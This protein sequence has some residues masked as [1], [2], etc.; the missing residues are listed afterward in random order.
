MLI[1]DL[2][3]DKS[4][5]GKKR[6]LSKS[7][8]FSGK[9]KDLTLSEQLAEAKQAKINKKRDLERLE[10]HENSKVAKSTRGL[11]LN[12]IESVPELYKRTFSVRA[13]VDLTPFTRYEVEIKLNKNSRVNKKVLFHD[14]FL[15]KRSIQVIKYLIDGYAT[16]QITTMMKVG[17]S[18]VNHIRRDNLDL[19]E[20]LILENQKK[21]TN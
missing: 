1:T 7:P 11:D 19:I 5:K 20:K 16:K 6:P 14:R 15:T 17:H 10:E 8:Y 12:D 9:K 2:V 18:T 13:I 3:D 21:Q 4:Q